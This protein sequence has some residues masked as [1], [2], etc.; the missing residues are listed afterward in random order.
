MYNQI[1]RD[2]DELHKLFYDF[3]DA[4]LH[5]RFADALS[6]IEEPY[7]GVGMGEQGIVKNKA[8]A[9]LILRDSYRPAKDAEIEFDIKDITVNFISAD[10]AVLTGE[11]TVIN[12]PHGG[13]PM[14]SGLMQTVGACRKKDDWKISFTHSSPAVLTLE[15]VEAYPIRFLDNTLSALKAGLRMEN[16]AQLDAL[17]GVLN[18]DG[19]EKCIAALMADYN[20]KYNTALFMMDLDDFKKINDRLGH[21]VGDAVLQQVAETLRNAFRENDAV[22]RIGGDEF[23]VFLT[24]DFTA[25]FLEKKANELLGAM[26]LR[27]DDNNQ[28]PVSVSI[29]IAYG[30]ARVTFEKLYRTADIALYTAKRAGKC[31]YHLIN[32]DTNAHRG[33]SGSGAKL[34]SLQTLLEHSD[35]KEMVRSKTPYEALLENIPGGVV[36]YEFTDDTIKVTHCNEWFSRLVGY[37]EDEVEL[38]EAQDPLALVHPDDITMMLEA[39]QAF[40]DGADSN[41]VTYRVCQKDGS[42]T[43]VNQTTTVTERRPGSIIVYGIESDVDEAVRLKQELEKSHKELKAIIANVPSGVVKFELTDTGIKRTHCND[44]FINMLSFTE[45]EINERQA[46]NPLALIHPEDAAVVGEAIASIR[47]GLDGCNIIYRARTKDGG[48]IYINEIVTVTERLPN[49]IILYGIESDVGELVCLKEQ[50]EEA[51]ENLERANQ[52]IEA[53]LSSGQEE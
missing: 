28:I 11:V 10:V 4:G 29:G 13:Q 19:F 38:L 20:P 42:Y 52:K 18:R 8:Q 31:C 35:D 22:G 25:K 53:L 26:R 23:M 44:W 46:N 47:N 6:L 50:L 30:R 9:E 5:G 36:M 3:L 48:Y 2:K 51:K 32:S 21:Q 39:A 17:T 40:R 41:N 37:T 45:E 16:I 49:C 24:G 12:I 1:D 27:T 34:L 43:Y 14:R 15:S 33:H 7:I